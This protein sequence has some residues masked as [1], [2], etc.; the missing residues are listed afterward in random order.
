M[1]V[2]DTN[3]HTIRKIDVNG[4]TTTLAGMATAFGFTDNT[5]SAARFNTPAGIL[6]AGNGLLYVSDSGNQ[7]I[8]TVTTG[9][10]MTVTV[11]GTGTVGSKNGPAATATFND[12]L[13]LAL[14][15]TGNLFIVDEGNFAIRKLT[16]QG[17]VIGVAGQPGT[18]GCQD[19]NGTGAQFNQPSGLTY[20]NGQLFI[21][22][23][24][25]NA[26]R[27]LTPVSNDVAA[28]DLATSPIGHTR[29]LSVPSA[30]GT[31]FSWVIQRRPVGSVLALAN[32]TTA[33]PTFVPDA[34]GVYTFQVTSIG[35]VSASV[36]TVD[37]KATASNNTPPSVTSN[38]SAAP[39][40]A[41][42]GQLVTFTGAAT[43]AEGDTITY[44]WDFGDG[45][46]GSGASVQHAYAAV[47]MYTATLTV[48]DG[49]A[50]PVSAGSVQMVVNFPTYP[51]PLVGTGIDTDG[52]GFSDAFEL[53]VG[54]NPNDATSTPT[55][56]PV[57]SANLQALTLTKPS[58]KLNLKKPG[59]DAI[60]FSGTVPVPKG[61]VA[62]GAKIYFDVS[63]VAKMLT[64]TKT[65]A[66]AKLTGYAAKVTL[67][68]V[69][70]VIAAQT[71]KF[72]VTLTKGTFAATLAAAGLTNSTQ[73]NVKVNVTFTF[74]FN[75]AVYQ[76]T[77]AL[78]PYGHEGQDRRREIARTL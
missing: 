23:A 78:K 27:V 46:S 17:N 73:K 66:S 71:A 47:G 52:D 61:F 68:A 5:G 57:T 49:I 37:F 31:T 76:K 56:Q 58:I 67:K 25:N 62:A 54:T 41:V 18:F 34:I 48:S 24:A 65:G 30:S 12:P 6:Y 43:D 21:C 8:R 14:D 13:G 10:G 75:N 45:M 55:G 4:N 53:A 60:A 32:A 51:P 3:N 77:Q 40:P 36:T 38:A 64:L 26:I 63:G 74:I 35:A 7:A 16:P 33:N 19:G 59:G 29:H 28:I 15:G 22:D 11:A 50:P 9:T 39:N 69:K 70:G 20:F 2:T 44:A 1:Y 42:I 72:S